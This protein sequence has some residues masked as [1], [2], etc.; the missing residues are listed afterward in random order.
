[1]NELKINIFS[2]Q[3]IGQRKEQQDSLVCQHILN[4]NG[5]NSKGVLVAIADGMGGLQK[6]KVISKIAIEKFVTQFSQ[7]K[8]ENII[9][10]FIKSF[11]NTNDL[12]I[13]FSVKNNLKNNVGTTL[14]AGFI[15]RDYLYFASVGDSRIYHYRNNIL[16]KITNEHN[17]ENR[18]LEKLKNVEISSDFFNNEKHKSALTSYI[19]IEVLEEINISNTPINLKANDKLL[20]CSD[21]LYNALSDFEITNILKKNNDKNTISILIKNAINKKK[22]HQ[23]NI[24]VILINFSNKN[25][26]KKESYNEN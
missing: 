7:I 21:G 20:F 26:K 11:E 23:D 14:L 12:V 22:P 13:D 25:N 4:P 8:E 3:H 1:M 5:K 19:G 17:Y 15:V 16:T 9:K 6:G 24:S 18:L 10:K 2:S